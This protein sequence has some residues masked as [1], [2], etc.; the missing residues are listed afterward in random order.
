MTNLTLEDAC[1]F[2]CLD[3][4]EPE[5]KKVMV[6]APQSFQS[7]LNT[8]LMEEFNTSLF[9]ISAG[10]FNN[11]FT[12][13]QAIEVIYNM[14]AHRE[15][16]GNEIE[17]AVN[18]IFNESIDG[19]HTESAWPLP[20]RVELCDIMDNLKQAGIEPMSEGDMI[21]QLG[22]SPEEA[23]NAVDFINHYFN[24]LDNPPVYISGQRHG[25]IQH[26]STWLANSEMIE[27]YGYDQVLANP[28]KRLLTPEERA[29]IPSGGRRKEFYNETLDV[30]TFESDSL[31]EQ[32]QFAVIAYLAGFLP[33]VSIVY[34]GGKSY[35]ATFSLKG[36]S[37]EQAD[38]VRQALANLGGDR[39]VM[40]PHQLVRLGG[41]TRSGKGTFQRVLWINP[42]ARNTPPTIDNIAKLL[43]PHLPAALPSVISMAALMMDYPEKPES[44][45]DGVLGIGDKLIVSA[46]SKAGKTWLMLGLAYA[47]QNGTEWMGHSCK[48]LN[49]LYVNFE[50]TPAWIAER[51]RL[52]SRS[53]DGVDHPD[54]LNLKNHS[55]P[56]HKLSD[57]VRQHIED[58]GKHYGFIILDPIYKML[59][60]KDEN[61]NG[62]IANLLNELGRMSLEIEA[63]TA[64]SHHHSKGN[65]SGVDAM[66]RMAGAGVWAR[67]PDAIIDLVSHEDDDCYVVETLAR[68]YVKP[69]KVVVQSVFPSF[70]VIDDADANALRKPG[71]SKKKASASEV[72]TYCADHHPMGLPMPRLIDKVA[73]AFNVGDGTAR[74]RINEAI[75][76]GELVVIGDKKLIKPVSC[77]LD[78]ELPSNDSAA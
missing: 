23:D 18:K 74:S 38:A 22:E 1:K 60:D 57:H 35:H 65:K 17:R 58:S 49:V 2:E 48:K 40:A 61:S 7:Y 70:V 46:P 11:N 56:W 21:A 77:I 54:M 50:L 28:M 43:I 27:A 45:I 68:N 10:L 47:V 29:S 71:G 5:T 33:L 36:L 6:N 59:E 13:E 76:S 69:P 63:A 67:D 9:G 15:P 64:F 72:V 53:A 8:A 73:P 14:P 34:S 19:E 3:K 16:N 51:G 39:A 62:D 24:G 75:M 66:D 44:V 32:M 37:R 12:A 55:V 41:V 20:K 25:S 52:V 78:A 42:E 4:L 26:V 31:P 30:I